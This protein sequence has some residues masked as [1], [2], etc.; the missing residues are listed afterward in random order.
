MNTCR[1]ISVAGNRALSRSSL[2]VI[3]ACSR[4]LQRPAIYLRSSRLRLSSAMRARGEKTIPTG[5]FRI[6]RAMPSRLC[7][8][9]CVR[10]TEVHHRRIVR[11]LQ[12]VNVGT[13]PARR[14]FSSVWPCRARDP[15]ACWSSMN[16]GRRGRSRYARCQSG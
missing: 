14:L 11:R 2:V 12:I 15:R 7:S 3:P 13:S 1:S 9:L 10:H 6:T 8:T 16:S 5:C 4:G